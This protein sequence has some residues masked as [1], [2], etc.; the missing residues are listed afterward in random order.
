ML[1]ERV[2]SAEGGFEGREPIDG[3]FCDIEEDLCAVDDS[4]SLCQEKPSRQWA[5]LVG[6]KRIHSQR[7]GSG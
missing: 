6:G 1:D 7:F 4:V 5:R 3:L 2:Y